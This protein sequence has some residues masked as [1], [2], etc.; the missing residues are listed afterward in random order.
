MPLRLRDAMFCL[1]DNASLTIRQRR[2]TDVSENDR[3]MGVYGT[4][5][6]FIEFNSPI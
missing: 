1:H 3:E 5:G 2:L 4:P 6:K